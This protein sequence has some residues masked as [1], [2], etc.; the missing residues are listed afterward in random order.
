M[1]SIAIAPLTKR[2]ASAFGK[3]HILTKS[4]AL[5]GVWGPCLG[6]R[7]CGCLTGCLRLGRCHHKSDILLFL[8]FQDAPSNLWCVRSRSWNL[9]GSFCPVSPGCQEVIKPIL[10]LR[11]WPHAVVSE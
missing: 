3:L 11:G 10:P 8:S 6:L 1:A 7:G 5:G 4:P 9:P 2:A